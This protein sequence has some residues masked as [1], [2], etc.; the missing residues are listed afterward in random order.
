MKLYKILLRHCSP[1]D[2]VEV[3]H[4]YVLAN[5]EKE[6]MIRLDNEHYYE[7]WQ[8]NEADGKTYPIYD[9][10]YNEIGKE[11]YLDRILRLRGTYHDPNADYSDAY[12]GIKHWGWSEGQDVTDSQLQV[13]LDLGIAK[14]WR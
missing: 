11:K 7:I 2:C 12:Y 13:L 5:S 9:E 8:E 3:V 14:D 6:L 4:S 10:D 1:K